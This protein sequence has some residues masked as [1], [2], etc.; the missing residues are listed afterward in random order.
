MSGAEGGAAGKTTEAP[1]G[2]L[3]A[4]GETV[5]AWSTGDATE[6]VDGAAG[7]G[8]DCAGV[9]GAVLRG[10]SLGVLRGMGG[11]GRAA[12]DGIGRLKDLRLRSGQALTS[13][14]PRR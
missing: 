10:Q 7:G 2:T 14:N 9:P 1:C 4:G 12:G 13:Q 3:E 8:V 5:G 11:G 6:E